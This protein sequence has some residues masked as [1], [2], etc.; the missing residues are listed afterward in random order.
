MLLKDKMHK[1][2]KSKIHDLNEFEYL[3]KEC[4]DLSLKLPN[5]KRLMKLKKEIGTKLLELDCIY[6]AFDED[7]DSNYPYIRTDGRIE[8]CTSLEKANYLKDYLEKYSKGHI[9]IKKILKSDIKSFFDYFQHIGI[10]ALKLDSLFNSIDLW[11]KDFYEFNHDGQIDNN[12]RIMRGFF[13]RDLQYSNRALNVDNKNNLMELMMIMRYNSYRELGNSL[14]YTFSEIPYINDITYCTEAAYSYINKKNKN[15]HEVTNLQNV[16]TFKK[17][18][19][20]NKLFICAFT[21]YK[22]AKIMR[23]KFSKMGYNDSIII[24]TFDELMNYINNCDGLL[25]DIANYKI[26]L[27]KKDFDEILKFKKFNKIIL[28]EKN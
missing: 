3:Q 12:N 10:Y 22:S 16:R 19:D 17:T 8:I 18:N 14:I 15:M 1:L 6:I 28:P 7:F 20:N 11:F 5:S 9:S 2:K 21:D 25:L 26:E 27:N 4:Y 13:L 24:I 23:D